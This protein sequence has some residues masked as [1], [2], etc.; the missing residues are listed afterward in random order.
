MR[1][2][3]DAM[4]GRL[5]ILEEKLEKLIEVLVQQGRH[6]E[7]MAAMDQR[8]VNQGVRLDDIIKRFNDMMDARK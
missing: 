5:A 4:S 8:L 6:E 2:K 7:R 3:I 1:N